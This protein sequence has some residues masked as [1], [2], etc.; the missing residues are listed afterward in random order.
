MS[1]FRHTE[2]LFFRGPYE[3]PTETIKSICGKDFGEK[4][5]AD[6]ALRKGQQ[7]LQWKLEK[8]VSKPKMITWFFHE[9]IPDQGESTIMQ[10]IV[11]IHCLEVPQL[12]LVTV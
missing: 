9:I 4:M 11:R 1:L 8:E 2:R 12:P 5:L 10:A 3:A 6:M 7:P